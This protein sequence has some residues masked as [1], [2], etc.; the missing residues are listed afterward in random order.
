MIMRRASGHPCSVVAASAL[1]GTREAMCARPP[2]SARC[3]PPACPARSREEWLSTLWRYQRVRGGV[4]ANDE[5]AYRDF[6]AGR[7]SALLRTAYLLTGDEHRAE[8]LLQT[9]LAKLWLV[10][11]RVGSEHPE[12]YVRRILITTSTSWWRRRWQGERP[13]SHAMPERAAAGDFTDRIADNDALIT[14]LRALT[15]RQRAVVVLRYAEDLP[16]AEVAETLGIS[17]GSVKTL[18]S[19]GLARLRLSATQEQEVAS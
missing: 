6:V 16:E 9:S 19:R 18:A 3:A 2:A 11:G 1:M 5:E 12:A 7:W 15:A 8:D 4:T 13:M 17:V 10:W 14:A